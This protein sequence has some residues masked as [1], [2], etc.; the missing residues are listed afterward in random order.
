MK[1]V[2][3]F[4]LLMLSI[5]FFSCS[6]NAIAQNKDDSSKDLWT[7]IILKNWKQTPNSGNE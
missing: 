1:I 3:C 5:V 6:E 4:K 7:P 2:K